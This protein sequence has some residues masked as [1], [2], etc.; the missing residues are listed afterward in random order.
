MSVLHEVLD[1]NKKY[2]EGFGTTSKV[3]I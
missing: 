3:W 1:A 2:V